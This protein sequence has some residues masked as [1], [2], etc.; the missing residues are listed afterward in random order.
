[1]NK[2]YYRIYGLTIVSEIKIQEAYECEIT[3][4]PDVE[5]VFG[6]IPEFLRDAKAKGYGTWTGDFVNA[7]FNTPGAAQYY[8]E[9]GRKIIVEPEENANMDLVCSMIL[10]AGLCLVLLQRNEP[11]MHGSAIA[12]DNEAV[13]ICGESGAGK[14]TITLELLKRNVGFLADDTVRL[15]IEPSGVFAEPTYPQQKLCR[16]QVEKYDFATEKLRYVDEFRD[17]FA[18]MRRDIYVDK[19]M[20]LAC[21]IILKKSRDS[22]KV[23]SKQLSGQEFLTALIDNLYLSDTYKNITGVPIELMQKFIMLATHVK[24]Y[25]VYRPAEGDTVK[26][27]LA[28]IDKVLQLC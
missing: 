27:V 18:L 13:M 24:I 17:K 20:P 16:D 2:F 25:E 14:S 9:H 4:T 21:M 3:N 23:F 12:I 11:V 6:E 15:R 1:M 5:V 28:E 10:S 8:I 7:W 26:D 19:A 22:E